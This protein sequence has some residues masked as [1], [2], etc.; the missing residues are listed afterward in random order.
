MKK[1]FYNAIAILGF[2]NLALAQVPSYVPTN[3][4]VGYWPFN[5][6][7]NDASGNGNNGTVNGANLTSDRF[8]N[9]NSSYNFNG[10]S[11]YISIPHNN[12]LN[13]PG[14]AS[15]TF[16][17]W[18]F[19]NNNT[20]KEMAVISKGAGNGDNSK[21][22]YIFSI[23][24]NPKIGLELANYP[25]GRWTTSDGKINHNSW[26]HIPVTY[27]YLNNICKYYINGVLS[28]QKNYP[29]T[30]SSNGDTN[31]LF[32]GKQGYN[33]NCNWMDGKIDDIGTWNRALTQTEITSLYNGNI[34]IE[35]ISVTDTLII[36][37]N[38][39]G[40]NPITF[41]NTLKVYPNP[42][43]DKITIDNG[44]LTKMTGYSI[45][46]MNSLGQQVFQNTINQQQFN[47]D[48]TSWGGNGMYFLQLID[49]SGNI[50]DI[51][52]ILLQ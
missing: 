29:F 40:Y 52:K 23:Y 45:K 50:V 13:F 21:D 37:V 9:A 34:C 24:E 16:S 10:L 22:T 17:T 3:G 4:L 7:A 42:T 38:R 2:A 33:C 48:I 26:N 8:G 6:N 18:I 32:I 46:I 47:I 15:F 11:N 44:N 30:P 49:K 41:E 35:K 12:N 14:N 5:G 36:N 27:D 51:R 31:S 28:G 20:R 19:T 43:K 1:V 25:I 39:T